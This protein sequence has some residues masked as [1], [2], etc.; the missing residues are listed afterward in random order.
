MATLQLYNHTAQRFM[1]GANATTDTYKVMLL[2]AT[3]TFNAAHTT[4]SEVSNANA[5]EVFGNGWTQLGEAL[6]SVVVSLITA[7]DAMFDAADISK[8]I[9]GGNLGPYKAL[10]VYND[11]DTND[12]PVVYLQLT[13]ET[14]TVDGTS[15]VIQWPSTGLVTGTV[16]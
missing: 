4:L 10:V 14:T 11:T 5:Y 12:P 15:V 16:A 1:S 9:S 7:N 6:T 13:T 8:A 2:N 3:A